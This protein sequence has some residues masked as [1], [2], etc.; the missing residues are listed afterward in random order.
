MLLE[1]FSNRFIHLGLNSNLSGKGYNFYLTTQGLGA[2][3]FC[4]K[5]PRM[6]KECK[7]RFRRIPSMT[8]GFVVT[9]CYRLLL[10]LFVVR[11][12]GEFIL[13]PR[14]FRILGF[15]HFCTSFL[16]LARWSPYSSWCGG[17][18]KDQYL[19]ILG[20][21]MKYLCDV[22]WGHLITCLVF[23][24]ISNAILSSNAVLFDG[25]ITQ[26]WIYFTSSICSFGCCVSTSL[27]LC[28]SSI[29]GL[30]INSS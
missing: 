22:S 7:S 8:L 19:S 20:H 15:D 9:S 13:H 30:V 24:E 27:F 12:D 2:H 11:K 17:T 21:T 18:C 6:H 10:W 26:A 16:F 3:M 4:S 29:K 28:R 23:Q 14:Y 1:F 25:P 5:T